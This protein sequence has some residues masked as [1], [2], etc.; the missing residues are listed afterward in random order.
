MKKILVVAAHPD[1]EILGCGATLAREVKA[2]GEA[3]VLI[4]ATGATSRAT[5]ESPVGNDAVDRLY[6]DACA[7]NLALGLPEE[8]VCFGGFP[9]Q[10]LDVTPG[11]KIKNCVRA[12]VERFRPDAVFTH[13]PGDYNADHRAVFSA[14]LWACRPCLGE[15]HPREIY[16]FEVLSSTEWSWRTVDGFRP[17]LYVDVANSIDAKKEALER[18][19]SELRPYPHPRSVQGV[20]ILARKRGLEVSLEYAECF[21]VVRVI[22]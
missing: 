13:H 18:Y 3:R 14:V 10:T 12:E 4:V 21:E 11:L 1:D 7:A 15:F 6:R 8:A 22:R 19:A 5:A 16:A 17:N 2:G 20:E 9:D